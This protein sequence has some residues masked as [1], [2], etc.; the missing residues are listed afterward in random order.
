MPSPQAL[1]WMLTIPHHEFVPYLP[2]ACCHIIGQ[3]E[4]GEGGF[5]HWQIVVSFIRKTTLAGCRQVF[6]N[7]HAERTR[8]DAA[9]AYVW[10]EDTRVEGTQFEI[11]ELPMR[12]NCATDWNAVRKS[13]VGGD[14]STIPDDV[15]VRCYNQLRRI[16]S[17]HVQPVP[18]VRTCAVFWGRSATGKSR[19]A[20]DEAGFEAYAKDP[21]TKWWDGYCGHA[22][23][24]IDEFR[25]TI[26]ISHLLRWL[27]RYPVRIECKGST[28]PLLA[29]RFWITSN[30]DPR[31][32]Y[33]DVDEDT[34]EALLRRL[35]ITHFLYFICSC[36]L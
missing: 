17:D 27:D 20:W 21:R 18:M 3:L 7:G 12:R 15:Y 31:L 32:W 26:D 8:S 9:R 36:S 5:L 10:K 2:P 14:L 35:N 22:N 23:V 29:S 33:P 6:G 16:G 1:Y 19:R 13:A 24:V 30:L 28:L 4:L 25:G 11:G 34:K